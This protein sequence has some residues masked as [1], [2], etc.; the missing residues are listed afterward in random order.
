M[1]KNIKY[2]I[3]IKN[4]WAIDWMEA[5]NKKFNGR[6]IS[7]PEQS[8]GIDFKEDNTLFMTGKDYDYP[9]RF[10]IQTQR[11]REKFNEVLYIVNR[12]LELN[13]NGDRL[14]LDKK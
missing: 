4:Q 6:I 5:N 8:R 14:R 9:E 12:K 13:K 3:A 10:I 1:N 2:I 7:I 11:D